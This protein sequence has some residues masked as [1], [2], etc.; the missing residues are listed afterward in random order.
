MSYQDVSR[1]VEDYVITIFEDHPNE[2]FFYHNLEHTRKVAQ[3][4]V[5]IALFYKMN[6]E[7]LFVVTTA[8]W[9]HDTGYLFVG[10][11]DHEQESVRIMTEF[12]LHYDLSPMLIEKVRQTIMATK[13]LAVPGSLSQMIL[14]DADT[15]HFGTAEFKRT[16]E[17]V[18]K[19]IELMIGSMPPGWIDRTI[20][21]LENHRY[22]TSYCIER[23]EQGKAK[24]IGWLRSLL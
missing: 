16:D 3:R 15:Y 23:L 12:I 14:C 9:F 20:T 4:A 11:I 8:A 6:D 10:P 7:P 19:E 1:A 22:Y 5:E 18:K 17:L 13:K 24:N 21:M 2:N